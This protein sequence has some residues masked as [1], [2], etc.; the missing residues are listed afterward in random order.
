[1]SLLYRSCAAVARR[2]SYST[3]RIAIVSD[4][5]YIRIL[6]SN[7]STSTRPTT[8]SNTSSS[9][10]SYS[11]SSPQ[12][13]KSSPFYD[14]VNRYSVSGQQHRIAVANHLFRAAQFQAFRPHWYT[15]TNTNINQDDIDADAEDESESESK[16]AIKNTTGTG[17]VRR[18]RLGLSSSLRQHHAMLTLHI[19]F[20]HRRLLAE[21]Q[22]PNSNESN[23]EHK[24]DKNSTSTAATTTKGKGS[25]QLM[26]QEELFDTFWNDTQAR[27]RAAGVHELSVNKFLKEL[28]QQS[29]LQMT[30]Y[31]HACAEF[32]KGGKDGKN[33]GDG[34]DRSKRFEI[35]CDGV[36]RHLLGGGVVSGGS[37]SGSSD[38]SGSSEDTRSDDSDDSKDD[39]KKASVGEVKGDDDDIP[40]ELIRRMGAYVEYQLDNIVFRLPDD[41]F[42]RGMVAWG[43]MPDL[44]VDVDVDVDAS[45]EDKADE[46]DAMSGM[47]F[48]NDEW[49]RVL[50]DAGEPYYWNM[51]SDEVTWTE[52]EPMT[53]INNSQ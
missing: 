18:L 20:L 49:V 53:M 29:M 1:M 23:D 25:F 31:D 12:L 6:G 51:E 36:W 15:K 24:N 39:S 52:P 40:D 5:T 33:G 46:K 9:N 21:T 8:N 17:T 48:I 11:S 28:Q 2:S 16:T 43:S 13:Q 34:I 3:P 26:I 42:D 35:I 37:G 38:D 50:N 27:I 22:L 19:W 7:T 47:D 10:R 41:Y 44:D 4:S 45:K 32:E 14:F 30:Q